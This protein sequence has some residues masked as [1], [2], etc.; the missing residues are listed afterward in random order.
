MAGLFQAF[1]GH[2]RLGSRPK[3]VAARDRRQ[4]YYSSLRK[5]DCVPAHDGHRNERNPR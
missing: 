5:L 2:P 3:D 1:P 4:V